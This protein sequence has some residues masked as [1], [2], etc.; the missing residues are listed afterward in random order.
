[1]FVTARDVFRLAPS[2]VETDPRFSPTRIIV[3]DKMDG[4]PLNAGDGPLRLVVEGD[5]DA[6]R[7]VRNLAT[8]NVRAL[9]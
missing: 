7:L 1:M 3:A 4:Q 9:D 5:L 6:G 2:L 8:I